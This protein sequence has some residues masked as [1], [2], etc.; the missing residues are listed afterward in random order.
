MKPQLI[1]LLLLLLP[2][3]GYAQSP[4]GFNYQAALRDNSGELIADR[5]VTLY[6][7]ILSGSANGQVVYGERHTTTTTAFGLVNLVVGQGTPTSGTLGNVNWGDGSKYLK[8]EVEVGN[9]GNRIS[10]GSAQLMS[11]PYALYAENGG[12]QGTPGP[13]GPAGPQGA[14]GP[15]GPQGQPGVQGPAGP[16]GLAGKDGTGVK[17]VGSVATAANLNAGYNGEVGDMYI[18]ANTGE[19]HVWDGQKWVK[20]GQIQGPAG[21]SGP[22]GPQGVAGP[23]GPQG[24]PGPQGPQGPAGTYTAGTGIAINGNTLVN[25]GDTNPND[26][27]TTSTQAGGDLGGTYPNPLVGRLQGR[28]VA[29]TAPGNG[30]VLGWDGSKWAPMVLPQIEQPWTKTGTNLL[31]NTGNVGLGVGITNPTARLE[32]RHAYNFGTPHLWLKSITNPYAAIYMGTETSDNRVWEILAKSGSTANS[33]AEFMILYGPEQEAESKFIITEQGIYLGPHEGE[34][35]GIG[36]TSPNGRLDVSHNSTATSPQ[37]TVT[38]EENDF[39]RINFRTL[40]PNGSVDNKYWTMAGRSQ[41]ADD[42]SRLNFYYF[43]GTSGQD[44]LSVSGAGRVGIGT[45]SPLEKL[46]VAGA[47]KLGNATATENGTIRWTGADF[48]GRKANQWVSFT[49][50]GSTS[51]WNT[52]GTNAFY[53]NGNVGIGINTPQNRLHVHNTEVTAGSPSNL[54]LTNASSGTTAGDGLL[55]T[56]NSTIADYGLM[57][58][59]LMRENRPLGFGANNN[60]HLFLKE[61]GLLGLGT[62]EPQGKMEID[63]NSTSHTNPHLTLTHSSNGFG[64]V[65]FRSDV[66]ANKYWTIAARTQASDAASQFNLFYHNG[67]SGENILSINGDGN[68]GVGNISPT[69]KF[70]VA[71]NARVVKLGINTAPTANEHLNVN[72]DARI[73]N[74]GI[75]T[76]PTERLDVNGNIRV[77]GEVNRSSTGAANLVPICYGNVDLSGTIN[78]GS[79]NFTVVRTSEGVYEITITGESYFF[80]TYVTQATLI[81]S[82]GFIS[83]SSVNGKLLVRTSRLGVGVILENDR[84]F[85]FTVFKP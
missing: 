18:A 11:V 33:P 9:N 19:G 28:P 14:Q 79:G 57:G 63:Y 13:A 42:A 5:P 82:A 78:T 30:N 72:G 47:V 23:L 76:S 10:M 6:F 48:E 12:G 15:Q 25:T 27:I 77:T 80:D 22:Q 50:A 61:S 1:H 60:Y 55:L 8:I 58:G 31:Y 52:N 32:V 69:E 65:S 83:T 44:I 21:Q 3:A 81:G 51:V 49:S 73:N 71:G 84:N 24:V 74:L 56:L 36:T 85:C 4:K 17:I 66:A 53:N 35:V 41:A 26:D 37:I 20:V 29:N 38:E 43:N 54:Q 34:K 68:V 70:Q 2:L 7:Q 67:T 75:N 45:T 39:G 59:L 16:Q 40:I 62:F 64:R 46:D